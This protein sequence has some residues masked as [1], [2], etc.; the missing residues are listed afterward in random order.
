MFTIY[1][2]GLDVLEIDQ[3]M[4][5]VKELEYENEKLKKVITDKEKKEKERGIALFYSFR[6]TLSLERKI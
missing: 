6:L 2:E 5:K 1:R 3:L 4:E